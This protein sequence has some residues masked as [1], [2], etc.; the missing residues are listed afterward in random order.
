MEVGGRYRNRNGT[1]IVLSLD[2]SRRRVKVRYDA[3]GVER[4]LDLE[5]Q[6]RINQNMEREAGPRSPA[7]TAHPSAKAVVLQVDPD[8]GFGCSPWLTQTG[9]LEGLRAGLSTDLGRRIEQ[10]V[11]Q[12]WRQVEFRTAREGIGL[13][14]ALNVPGMPSRLQSRL[15]DIANF[16]IADFSEPD[17]RKAGEQ[18]RKRLH[19]IQEHLRIRQQGALP[20]F[21][22]RAEDKGLVLAF[23]IGR[24]EPTQPAWTR[25]LDALASEELRNLVRQLEAEGARL[26]ALRGGE[27]ML[28]ACPRS[29]QPDW[30]ERLS[31]LSSTPEP[32]ELRLALEI[33]NSR[34]KKIAAPKDHLMSFLTRA[35]ALYRAA[36]P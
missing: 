21:L 17:G 1:Y 35:S 31:L 8:K 24:G 19:A 11:S 20:R 7:Q 36:E 4:E 13:A 3:D 16:H 32:L 28:E 18:A 6:L 10:Q 14:T 27:V 15:R 34:L 25:L 9:V 29:G 22:L 5:M 12:G 30:T 2:S 23:I 33:S 26:E